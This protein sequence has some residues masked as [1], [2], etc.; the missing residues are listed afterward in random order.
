MLGSNPFL[1]DQKGPAPANPPTAVT[2]PFQ[3]Y[4]LPSTIHCKEPNRNRH[5]H[6]HL[7]PS[8]SS[9]DHQMAIHS[10]SQPEGQVTTLHSPWNLTSRHTSRAHRCKPTH[11]ASTHR[12][13]YDD[14]WGVAPLPLPWTTRPAFIT[15]TPP[16]PAPQPTPR[17][18]CQP[19]PYILAF[20]EGD[21]DR[22]IAD[23]GPAA[24]GVLGGNPFLLDHRGSASLPAHLPPHHCPSQE[25][26]ASPI[27]DK[28]KPLPGCSATA[29]T[30]ALFYYNRRPPPSLPQP[31]QWHQGLTHQGSRG[32]QTGTRAR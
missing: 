26:A 5:N 3:N 9:Q 2:Q 4:G 28:P 31:L 29:T 10:L 25:G 17:L 21:I 30:P 14:G 8:A 13:P 11:P 15:G 27:H 24:L 16:T 23:R 32:R 22:W 1:L 19:Q 7:F 18:P 12:L 6:R 20:L